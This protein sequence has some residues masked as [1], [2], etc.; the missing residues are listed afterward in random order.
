MSFSGMVEK[1][2]T[3][4]MLSQDF[5]KNLLCGCNAKQCKLNDRHRAGTERKPDLNVFVNKY[6]TNSC[7]EQELI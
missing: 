2:F 4:L 3:T 7:T 1:Y 5:I 6:Y